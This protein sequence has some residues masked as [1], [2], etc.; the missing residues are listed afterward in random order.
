M[1]LFISGSTAGAGLNLLIGLFVWMALLLHLARQHQLTTKT[2]RTQSA[3]LLL[4]FIFGCCIIYSFIITPYKFGALQYAFGWLTDI[5]LFYLI[6]RLERPYL[7]V[8]VL[9]GIAALIAFYALYQ[10]F[11]G[12]ETLRQAVAQNPYLLDFVPEELRKEFIGRLH[13]NEPFGTFTYQNSMGGFL[14]LTIPVMIAARYIFRKPLSFVFL[15]AFIISLYVLYSTGAKGAWVA[16]TVGLAVWGILSIQSAPKRRVFTLICVICGLICVICGFIWPPASL[17]IRFGYWQGALE[18]IRHNP[19]GVGINGFA[20][21]YLFYKSADAGITQKAH[22]DFLQI[23]AEMG[24]IGLIMFAAIFTIILIK[25][26]MAIKQSDTREKGVLIGLVAGLAGFL[27]HCTVDFN[28]YVQGLSMSAWLVAGC[29]VTMYHH[30]GT[31]DT[32]TTPTKESKTK[33]ILLL[34]ACSLFLT[35]LAGYVIPRLIESDNLLDEGKELVKS[36]NPEE[37]QEGIEKLES[38]IKINPYSV[39]ILVEMAWAYHLNNRDIMVNSEMPLCIIYLEK[40]INLSPKTAILYYDQGVFYEVHGKKASSNT[41]EIFKKK[42]GEYFRKSYDLHP[43]AEHPFL[44]I[45][46]DGPAIE[47]D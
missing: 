47:N 9:S 7:F 40:A 5:I 21:A 10:H 33:G 20:D 13:S 29:I 43:T 15:L 46:G 14:V 2:Q 19:F 12:L 37:V 27:V 8:G 35:A 28:F 23:G 22:N 16:L 30:K 25:G 42:A 31:K 17:A 26:L 39:D 44:L 4:T 41:I 6:V 24:I 11:W 18:I 36:R 3:I 45:H 38:A 32:E 34:V 1:R